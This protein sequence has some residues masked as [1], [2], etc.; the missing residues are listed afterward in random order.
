M[1]PRESGDAGTD[2]GQGV[3]TATPLGTLG[4]AGMFLVSL[5]MW[6]R[7]FCEFCE[8][9]ECEGP[10]RWGEKFKSNGVKDSNPWGAAPSAWRFSGPAVTKSHQIWCRDHLKA[11]CPSIPDGFHKWLLPLQSSSYSS[12]SSPAPTSDT[13]TTPSDTSTTPSDTSTT[14]SDT[15][16]PQHCHPSKPSASSPRRFLQWSPG[17]AAQAEFGQPKLPGGVAI[18]FSSPVEMDFCPFPLFKE[19][20]KEMQGAEFKHHHGCE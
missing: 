8:F 19:A 20:A 11:P 5:E 3:G 18:L 16:H 17:I 9:C 15:G 4:N 7:E 1:T 13:S 6:Q 10:H 14:P 12:T 2:L